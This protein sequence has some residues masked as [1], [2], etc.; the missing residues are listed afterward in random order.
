[1]KMRSKENISARLTIAYYLKNHKHQPKLP[2]QILAYATVELGLL[3][4]EICVVLKSLSHKLSYQHVSEKKD[5][6]SLLK[7]I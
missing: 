6:V 1:M 2:F 3:E 5:N 7:Y 4:A